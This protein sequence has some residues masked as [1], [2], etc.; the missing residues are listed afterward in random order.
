[1]PNYSQNWNGEFIKNTAYIDRHSLSS[2][3]E[4]GSFEGITSNF[5][6]DELL[7]HNGTLVCC[8]PHE[9][10]Y[11][12]DSSANDNEIF[13]GQFFR[14]IDNIEANKE[15]I[16]YIRK[17]SEDVLHL[18]RENSFDFIY[19]DGHH[20]YNNVYYD[21]TQAFKLAKVDAWILFDDYLYN[22]ATFE[23]KHAI[24][25][26]LEENPNYRLLLKLNQVLIQKLEPGSKTENGQSRYQEMSIEK[27][28][29][30][31]TIYAAYCNLDSRPDRNEKMITELARVDLEI[32]IV[33]QRSYP[34]EELYNN[35]SD[36]EKQKVDV[37]V[38]RKT[39]G[40]IGCW[41]SQMEV[42]KE[43]LRQDKHAIVLED[44]ILVCND[45]PARLKIIF[46]Y[47]N[48]HEWDIFWFGGTY[49]LEP[50]WHKSIEGKHTHPDL[51]MCNCLLNRDWEETLHPAIV[52]TY[53]AF[54][55]HAYMVNKNRIQH[56]LDFLD[57]RMSIS[58]G[59]DFLMILE[60]PNLNTYAF[61]PGC[62]K[63]YDGQS[64]IGDGV[65]RFSGF[66]NL[67]QHWFSK[68]MDKYIPD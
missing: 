49:H 55:T 42:M 37:M 5:I 61:N 9:E 29:N 60:Q 12:L 17:K 36:E 2:V 25:R 41:Y 8:D 32:P 14:F 46:T 65:S 15:R 26:V 51:Q 54:S 18:L 27:L 10:N 21:G 44:D 31:E 56:V 53:G 64:N 66:R 43:A 57:R 4:I 13:K 63:Q 50:T 3:L 52:R 19:V 1:M 38:K 23:V 7:A 30:K 48:Q 35:F 22:S 58:M 20:R 62:M 67:G 16:W 39:P 47:L 6:C 59:I 24:D 40:A 33:R 11:E 45:F 34:W 68:S 28:F